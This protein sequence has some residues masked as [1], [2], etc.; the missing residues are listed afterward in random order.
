VFAFSEVWPLQCLPL[1]P[2]KGVHRLSIFLLLGKSSK[3]E[4]RTSVLDSIPATT[5]SAGASSG[6]SPVFSFLTD[7]FDFFP[8]PKDVK[9]G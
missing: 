2:T 9:L 6:A 4:H 8:L 1:G 5:F 3:E 7:F